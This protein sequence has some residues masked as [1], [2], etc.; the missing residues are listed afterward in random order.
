MVLLYFFKCRE[1]NSLTSSIVVVMFYP[2]RSLY[3]PISISNIYY[4]TFYYYFLFVSFLFFSFFISFFRLFF[5]SCRAAKTISYVIV[6]NIRP[7]MHVI[8]CLNYVVY[9]YFKCKFNWKM[10]K[11]KRRWAVSHAFYFLLTYHHVHFVCFFFLL[12]SRGNSNIY[13]KL[14]NK[15]NLITYTTQHSAYIFLFSL[16]YSNWVLWMWWIKQKNKIN[17]DFVPWNYLVFQIHLHFIMFFFSF[18]DFARLS[19]NVP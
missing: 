14:G 3:Y 19:I 4:V 2:L 15:S 8:E 10:A 5:I 13:W 6:F 12:T 17:F 9:V 1:S 7:F 18:F 16:L 11:I